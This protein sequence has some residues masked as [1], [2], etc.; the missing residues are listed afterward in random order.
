MNIFYPVLANELWLLYL[1]IL[2]LGV[3]ALL[4]WVK[5]PLLTETVPL[6]VCDNIADAPS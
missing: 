6:P 5:N 3:I 2:V 4:I 1:L